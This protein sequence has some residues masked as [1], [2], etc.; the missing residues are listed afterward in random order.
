MYLCPEKE[1]NFLTVAHGLHIQEYYT[2]HIF[3]PR[4]SSNGQIHRLDAMPVRVTTYYCS[5]SSSSLPV[6]VVLLP[7]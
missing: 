6:L 7:S 3:L 1:T 5:S 4:I 2:I